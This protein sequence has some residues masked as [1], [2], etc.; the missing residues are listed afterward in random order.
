MSVRVFVT[1]VGI[2]SSLGNTAESTFSRLVAGERGLSHIDLFDTTGQR[3]T[4]GAVVRGVNVPTEPGWSRS[5]AFAFE[6]AR[7]A[8][9]MA[10]L[11]PKH[12]RIG[13]VAGGTTAGMFENEVRVSEM[14]SKARPR[15]PFDTLRSHP[16]SSTADIL[17]HEL[18]PFVRLR[19][20]ASA[21]S[22]G[23]TALVFALDWLLEDPT[24]DAVLA[25]GTDGLCRLT[26]SG[27]NALG[28]IDPEPC[29]PFDR[30]RRGLN[31]GEGAGFLL[32]ERQDAAAR[33]NVT[34]LAELAGA[35]LGSEGHHITNPEPGGANAARVIAAALARAGLG[36]GELDYV[37]AHGTA[38]P[39]N[40]STES[41]A[42]V[43][44]L[45]DELSRV[46]VSSSKGQ[47]GHTLGAAGAIEAAITAMVVQRRILP[48]TI[49][50]SDPDPA[51][52]LAHIFKARPVTRVRAA[53]SNSF[54]FGGMDSA[55]VM[56]EPE[57]S[58]PVRRATRKVVL[59]GA[60]VVT[61]RGIET[62][63]SL[64]ALLS[65][66]ETR[67]LIPDAALAL[68]AAKA[69][70]FDRSAKLCVVAARDAVA[71]ADGQ[72]RALDR[73]SVG[74]AYGSA[75]GAVDE[76][77][78][79]VHRLFE[80]GPRLASPF[81]FPNLVPSSP[82]GNAS[83]YLGLHGPSLATA[84]LRSSGESAVLSAVELVAM[85]EAE[86]M[87]AGGITV[88]SELVDAVFFPLFDDHASTGKRS[89]IAAAV[90]VEAAD[91][92]RERGAHVFA[93]IDGRWVVPEGETP[94]LDAPSASAI[95]VAAVTPASVA[96]RLA[97]TAWAT[98]PVWDITGGTGDNE[99]AGAAALAAA[100]RLLA[101]GATREVLVVGPR[102]G[103]TTFLLLRAP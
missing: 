56:T 100:A 98:V 51:C 7:E 86:A 62:G 83:I 3:A 75:F 31:L 33:R 34:P 36:P 45:G 5:T 23:A 64:D 24:L 88:R 39:L 67:G 55:V 21:C 14:S 99:A 42:L 58:R 102:V 54:G 15:E 18:G 89:E 85:G 41:Q 69:R 9:A 65:A 27:F 1:G 25:G 93:S 68:D 72:G 49:G 16:L 10:G 50:L 82:I 63:P 90:V 66:K 26:L 32:L 73:R 48:P 28:A 38:T 57:L 8:L 44:V 103:W 76:S 40:D 92:A 17:Q 30:S 60:S 91:G 35:T 19:S 46:P 29:R 74:V 53:L 94:V 80:K 37:N 11:D 81:D 4:L 97:K 84:D 77:A 47:L 79:F 12:A 70:R 95:V 96:A 87:V 61:A 2:V 78:A 20:V 71:D 52:P 101:R 6:A 43:T 59:T 22:S 13:L